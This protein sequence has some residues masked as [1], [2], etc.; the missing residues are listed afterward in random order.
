M[1]SLQIIWYN[2]FPCNEDDKDNDQSVTLLHCSYDVIF[3]KNVRK[4]E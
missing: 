3:F 1:M 2:N 4:V